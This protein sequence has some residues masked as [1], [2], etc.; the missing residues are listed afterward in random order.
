[1]QRDREGER[2]GEGME[3][4]SKREK[5]WRYGARVKERMGGDKETENE[6]E[7]ERDEV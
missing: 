3:T 1:M 7:R 4:E 6:R 5:G 2:M